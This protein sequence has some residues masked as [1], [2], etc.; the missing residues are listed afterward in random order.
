MRCPTCHQETVIH[1]GICVRCGQPFLYKEEETRHL[2]PGAAPE[3][4][5]PLP[6]K[7][8]EIYEIGEPFCRGGMGTLFHGTDTVLK[9]G[10]AIKILNPR[11]NADEEIVAR[12]L[13]EANAA[14]SMDHPNIIPIYSTGNEGGY[15]FIV[16]KYIPGMSI[17][18]VLRESG[19]M[20]PLVAVA[21]AAP[22]LDGLQYIHQHGFVHRDIKPSNIML[23]QKG[24]AIILD[25][26]ILRIAKGSQLTQTGIVTGTP[27]YISPEQSRDSKY[28]DARGDIYS[29]GIVL[30]EMLVGE[31]PFRYDNSVDILIAHSKEIPKAP[32]K[33]F[34]NIPA[35][36]SAV[37]MRAL[38]KH[39][40]LRYQTAEEFC[41]A[42][43]EA[44]DV[45]KKDLQ[46]LRQQAA[47]KFLGPSLDENFATVPRLNTA[48]M[49]LTKPDAAKGNKTTMILLMTVLVLLLSLGII[50]W[51]IA[52]SSGS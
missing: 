33:V 47:L 15:Y 26:G 7:L 42:M 14:A 39:P 8:M 34:Q 49:N 28:V 3:D 35:A 36:L 37:V 38:E 40:S 50:I 12:F 9:R 17:A 22:I 20:N 23:D 43:L 16:M 29:F 21:L 19:R 25:F 18:K 41:L 6:P 10:V 52:S 4:R 32:N 31:P 51:V 13:R 30:Y 2:F 48:Q 46:P 44:M 11:Y 24:N 1:D 5:P 45:D 27:T